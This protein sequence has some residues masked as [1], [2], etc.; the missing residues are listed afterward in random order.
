MSPPKKESK[1]NKA[2][3]RCPCHNLKQQQQQQNW[4]QSVTLTMALPALG[5]MRSSTIKMTI[6]RSSKPRRP[7]RPLIW[8][9]SPDVICGTYIYRSFCLSIGTIHGTNTELKWYSHNLV[10]TH[11][12]AYQIFRILYSKSH[13]W[14]TMQSWKNKIS[15][16][17]LTWN[18]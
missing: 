16:L 10:Y 13:F 15:S 14:C 5:V 3:G 6:P 9:Y 4:K 8:M 12:K 7:A 17:Q 1:T 18:A 2:D 11:L